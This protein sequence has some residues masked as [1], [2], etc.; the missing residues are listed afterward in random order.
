MWSSPEI[1][2]VPLVE[3]IWWDRV[4]ECEYVGVITGTPWNPNPTANLEIRTVTRPYG[5]HVHKNCGG[6]LEVARIDNCVKGFTMKCLKCGKEFCA[7]A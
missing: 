2:I 4:N 5:K 1:E 6:D 3:D 7:N